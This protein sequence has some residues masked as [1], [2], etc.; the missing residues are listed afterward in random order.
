MDSYRST[1]WVL[2]VVGLSVSVVLSGVT[3]PGALAA[4]ATA[5][6]GLAQAASAPPGEP[7][8]ASEEARALDE[9]VATGSTGGGDRG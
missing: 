8:E 5:A 1:R 6:P 7:G 2:G 4:S 3:A 9:A